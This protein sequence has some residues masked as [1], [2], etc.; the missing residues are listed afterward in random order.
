M[1]RH[2]LPELMLAFA[3]EVARLST[4][5]RLNVGAVVTDVSMEVILG[6]GYNGN[7]VGLPNACDTLEPGACGCVHA[8]TNALI[9]AG[10]Q[11]KKMF[12]TATPCVACAKAIINAGVREVWASTWYRNKEGADVLVLGNVGLMVPDWNGDYRPYAQR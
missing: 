9:K 11:D 1:P 2:K 5:A 12:L 3:A 10:R 8:E 4:C 6:Y 7:A